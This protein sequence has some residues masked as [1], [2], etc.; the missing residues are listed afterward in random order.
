[1][2]HN[3]LVIDDESAV[4]KAFHFALEDTPYSLDT[5]ASGAEGL[6]TLNQKQYHLIFLDLKMPGMSGAETL[7]E[8]RKIDK[9]VPVY[10]VTAFHKE[11]MSELQSLRQEGIKF[12][13]LRKPLGIDEIMIIVDRVLQRPSAY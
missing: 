2:N 13:L 11:F 5:A 3:I 1:M 4:R 12:E 9:S 8:L 10:I 7:R 6:S